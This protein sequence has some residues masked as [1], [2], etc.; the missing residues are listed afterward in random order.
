MHYG[1]GTLQVDCKESVHQL[2][3]VVKSVYIMKIWILYLKNNKVSRVP[4]ESNSIQINEGSHTP[5]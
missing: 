5:S 3:K 2:N 1:I 4:S